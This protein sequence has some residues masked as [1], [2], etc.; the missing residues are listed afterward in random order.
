M[1]I[2][3]F[4][5]L[6]CTIAIVLLF[7]GIS[8]SSTSAQE[9]REQT[10]NIVMIMADDLGYECLNCYGGTSYETPNL[11]RLAQGGIRFNHCYSQPLCTPTRVQLMTGQYNV[12]NYERFGLL[13]S[14]Q[15]TFGNLL[16]SNG[17]ATCIAGKWQLGGSFD[18]PG[19]FGF[20]EYCLW[21]L[22]R[23]PERFPNPGL[24]INGELADFTNGEYGPDVCCNFACDFI[25]KNSDKP[26]LVYYPMILTHC[27]FCPTPD[28][29]DWDP[30]SE[31]SPTYKG[32]A[33]YFGDM[34]AYMDKL[35]GRIDQTLDEAGVRENTLVM[36]IGDNGTDRPVVS[37]IGDA[38]V[39]G[40]KNKTTD[41]GTRVPCIASWPGT[42]PSGQVS[43][44]LVDTTD[45]LP[46]MLE[47]AGL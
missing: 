7:S 31:G 16:R 3:S 46:T 9:N 30:A 20:D 15:L 41:G 36:F 17:Y 27:P 28:S 18:G 33:K 42:I 10:P 37:M 14:S 13:P 23:R 47:A 35:V 2:Q 29:A 40:D 34:V 39:A 24:E 1:F 11:N 25:R 6:A 22:N 4:N 26:F 45:F 32:D 19:R 43:D 12:R 5:Q 8:I 44:E 21:Q 38:E